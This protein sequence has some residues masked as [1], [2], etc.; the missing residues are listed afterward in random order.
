MQMLQQKCAMTMVSPLTQQQAVAKQ[1]GWRKIAGNS[2]QR[3]RDEGWEVGGEEDS[4]A[5]KE[6]E[7]SCAISRKTIDQQLWTMLKNKQVT[8]LLKQCFPAFTRNK[9]LVLS[10]LM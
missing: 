3:E 6:N 4:L 8:Q 5:F 10:G 9:T 2:A 1:M 7:V